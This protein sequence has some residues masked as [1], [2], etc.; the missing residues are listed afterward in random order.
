[1]AVSTLTTNIN[2]LQ[3]TG[4]KFVADRRRMD[5][6]TF[7]AQSVSAPGITMN[8]AEVPYRDHSSVPMVGDKLAYSALIANVLIDEN[9]SSYE[10]IVDWMKYN[11]A[12]N[13]PGV[14][15]DDA[16]HS[17]L[18]MNFLGSKNV[19]S[20]S[21]R[22]TDA[23]PTDLGEITMESTTDGSQAIV[24]PVTFRFTNFVIV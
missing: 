11:V 22:Y 7:F 23:F 3:P 14:L 2:L 4:F 19:L 15:S 8:A 20:R 9:M 17:D 21:I 10:E 5:N 12:N 13:D 16:H 24:C 1:M 18:T 6:I